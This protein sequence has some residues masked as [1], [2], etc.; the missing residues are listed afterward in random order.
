MKVFIPYAL[1]V[2]A[3]NP[4]GTLATGFDGNGSPV[5][6]N[7]RPQYDTLLAVLNPYSS[8]VTARFVFS[9]LTGA[10]RVWGDGLP[11][12]D[13][14]LQPQTSMATT[15]IP[16]NIF[17]DPPMDFL[18]HATVEFMPSPVNGNPIDCSV[19]AM[20]CGGKFFPDHWNKGGAHI[21]VIRE[22]VPLKTIWRCS[23]AIP[24]FQDYN[25]GPLS[26]QRSS[27]THPWLNGT[28]FEDS[29]YRSGLV[30]TNFDTISASFLVRFRVG[31]PYQGA[32]DTYTF[33]LSVNPRS[34]VVHDLYGLLQTWGYPAGRNSE[35]WLEISSS[36]P[37]RAVPYL[38]CSNASYDDWQVG[39]SF[40]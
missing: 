21:P 1:H 12:R 15:L 5:D 24:F 32:G 3:K 19:R 29:S 4:D 39:L 16:Y 28:V 35:G 30:I 9:G 13:Y 37:V 18:G 27:T 34:T 36:Y 25:H 31:V 22:E 11:Y 26:Y 6:G 10:P 2:P 17:P 20:L 23:Y 14:I 8:P 40:E 38:L 33:S 7:S